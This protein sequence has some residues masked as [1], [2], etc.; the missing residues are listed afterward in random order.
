MSNVKEVIA[1]EEQRQMD[2]LKRESEK[3]KK[4]VSKPK[5]EKS[6][7]DQTGVLAEEKKRQNK[8]IYDKW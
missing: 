5:E 6:A 2:T 4:K 8:A 1:E 3:A 7:Q